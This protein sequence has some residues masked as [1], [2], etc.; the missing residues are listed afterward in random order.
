MERLIDEK[1]LADQLGFKVQTLRNRRSRGEGPPYVKVG[2]S[3]RYRESDVEK[4]LQSKLIDPEA[5]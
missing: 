5:K 4:Y 2:R 3:V 1:V